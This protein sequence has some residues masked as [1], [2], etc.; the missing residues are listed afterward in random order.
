MSVNLE[1]NPKLF[2]KYDLSHEIIEKI[3]LK[4]HELL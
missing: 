3:E 1:F 2:N 4:F